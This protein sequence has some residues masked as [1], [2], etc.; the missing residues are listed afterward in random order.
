MISK[1][2]VISILKKNG[3]DLQK[4]VKDP[5]AFQKA[6]EVVYSKIPI[7]WRWFIGRSR[8]ISIM[9]TIKTQVP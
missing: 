4:I 6:S 3:I 7:P 9:N 2:K 5:M 1:E 8:V